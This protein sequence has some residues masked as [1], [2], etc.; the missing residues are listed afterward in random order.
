MASERERNAKGEFTDRIPPEAA[1]EAFDAREDVARPLTAADIMEAL[2]CSR[3]TAHNK[4]NTL[5]E[6]GR[7]ETRKIGAR[8]RVWWRPIPAVDPGRTAAEADADRTD[9]SSEAEQAIR[10]ADLPGSGRTLDARREALAAAYEYLTSH[11]SATKSDFL[12]DVYPKYPAKFETPDG[13]WNAIQ[14]A[15]KELPA[16]DPPEERGHLWKF[17]GGDRFTPTLG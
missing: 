4:L 1:L 14:P 8:S 3:R 12:D 9:H 11:P 10:A 5:V 13:W 15:L 16:V 7:L 2:D 6:A 17:L